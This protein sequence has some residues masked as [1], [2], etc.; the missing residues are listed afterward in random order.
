[1]PEPIKPIE[2][3]LLKES[4]RLALIYPVDVAKEPKFE[5]YFFLVMRR[6][7]LDLRYDEELSEIS[8]GG[9]LEFNFLGETSFGKGDDLLEVPEERP[10]YLSHFG[11]GISHGDIWLYRQQPADEVIEAL[12]RPKVSIGDKREFVDGYTSPYD[13]PTT[14]TETVM[15]YKS[16]VRFGLYNSS[17]RPIR[18]S[19]RIF[20]AGYNVVPIVD[21][22][23]IDKMLAGVKPVRFITIGTVKRTFTYMIPPEWKPNVVVVDRAVI[24]AALRGGRS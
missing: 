10:F 13:C 22:V 14:A 11:V 12:N 20:G 7:T 2:E 1:M 8:A 6:A 3:V 4:E 23:I 19:L 17:A 24:E 18:P 5:L 15:H 9:K 16:S 21:R